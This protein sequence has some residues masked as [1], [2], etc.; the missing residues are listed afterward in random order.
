LR[1]A[2]IL[3]ANIR[4]ERAGKILRDWLV[5]C[6]LANLSAKIESTIAIN[7]ASILVQAANGLS[8]HKTRAKRPAKSEWNFCRAAAALMGFSREALMSSGKLC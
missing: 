3:S 8:L 4:G 1:L 6:D 7:A 2:D 5:R